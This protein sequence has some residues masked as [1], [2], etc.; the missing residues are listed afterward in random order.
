MALTSA[1]VSFEA[2]TAGFGPYMVRIL[3][4]NWARPESERDLW[5]TGP[6]ARSRWNEE[7]FLKL[8]TWGR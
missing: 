7:I 3:A 4:V 6:D 8:S 5:K 1:N 2:E